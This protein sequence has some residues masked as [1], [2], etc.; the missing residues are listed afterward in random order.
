MTNKILLTAA[1]LTA[2]VALTYG[3]FANDNKLTMQQQVKENSNQ[4]QTIQRPL[5]TPSSKPPSNAAEVQV[6]K[7]N[8]N[9]MVAETRH[10]RAAPPPPMQ[11]NKQRDGRY[12]APKDHGHEHVHS[13]EHDNDH[14][15]SD[16]KNP[17]PP[18]TG[19]N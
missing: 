4:Q 12:I 18:P 3:Y 9:Q 1:S 16:E 5:P 2:L 8:E 11:A 10:V 14:S 13:H 7:N 6:L 19:A 15:H 17:P